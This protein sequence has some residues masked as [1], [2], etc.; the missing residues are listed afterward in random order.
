MKAASS[1]RSSATGRSAARTSGNRASCWNGPATSSSTVTPTTSRSTIRHS[2]AGS[3]L[4]PASRSDPAKVP[5]NVPEAH[6]PLPHR[7]RARAEPEPS[8]HEHRADGEAWEQQDAAIPRR[9]AERFQQRDLRQSELE[10]DL[11]T[12]RTDHGQQRHLHAFRDVRDRSSTS[13]DASL[14]RHWWAGSTEQDRPTELRAFRRLRRCVSLIAM[15]LL[16]PFLCFA[17]VCKL[18][19]RPV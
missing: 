15:R 1:P 13:E 11:D 12:V 18:R 3:T 5:A 19:R 10:P 4:T 16:L 9:R 17:A 6:L 7:R 8:E 14:Q 2:I